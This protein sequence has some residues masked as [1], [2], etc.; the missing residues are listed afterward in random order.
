[1]HKMLVKIAIPSIVALAGL[2]VTTSS[3]GKTEY[4]KKEKKACTYCHVAQGKKDLN[5]VGK[6]YGEHNH[7]LEGCEPKK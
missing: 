3:F 7:S 5:D 1:M 2:M 6:C 4:T